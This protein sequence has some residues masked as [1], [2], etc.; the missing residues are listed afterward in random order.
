[1]WQMWPFS[2]RIF[3]Y[4]FIYY[5]NCLAI[6]RFSDSL[7]DLEA[8]SRDRELIPQAVSVTVKPW[9]LAGL[10]IMTSVFASILVNHSHLNNL[11]NC[12]ACYSLSSSYRQ[13]YCSHLLFS[14]FMC[15]S[16]FSGWHQE[17]SW[18]EHSKNVPHHDN[19]CWWKNTK[20]RV[21]ILSC[22]C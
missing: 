9:E 4:C 10:I 19:K 22:Y 14:I 16:S 12:L 6:S 11:M 3:Q 8:K 20:V 21:K 17:L 1:M 2:T 5:L 13:M 15:M 7:W 18:K